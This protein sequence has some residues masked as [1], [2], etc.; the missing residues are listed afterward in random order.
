MCGHREVS[1]RK[2]LNEFQSIPSA[3]KVGHFRQFTDGLKPVPFKH[4]DLIRGLPS[5]FGQGKVVRQDRQY[6]CHRLSEWHVLG[7]A[8]ADLHEPSG[9]WDLRIR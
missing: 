9:L 6:E 7:Q 3:T 5:W 8:V 4:P 2:G 1:I